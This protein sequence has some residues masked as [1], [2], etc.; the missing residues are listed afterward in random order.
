MPKD[1]GRITENRVTA[2]RDQVMSLF[3]ASPTTEFGRN[4]RYAAFNALTEWAEW[5]A[6][7][8]P[9]REATVSSLL[10]GAGSNFRQKAYRVLAR[11]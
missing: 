8:D 10:E 9:A 5:V 11:V 4:T 3:T 6:P 1:A 2:Q 7:K